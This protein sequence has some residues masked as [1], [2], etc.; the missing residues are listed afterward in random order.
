MEKSRVAVIGL[1]DIARKAYL[2][3][4][5]TRRDV[6]PH[7]L[8]RTPRTLREVAADYRVPDE[9]LFTTLEDLVRRPLDAAFVHTP[10]EH[11]PGIVHRLLEAGI[12]TYVDKPLDYTLEGARAL[13]ERARRNRVSLMVGFNR[14]HAPGYAQLRG[15][16]RD[17]VLMQKNQPGI[18]DSPRRTVYDDFVHIADTLRFLAPEGGPEPDADVS[19]RV[20]GEQLEH[21][22]LRLTRPGWTALGT[23]HRRSGSK[24]EKLEV[25]GEGEKH[26]VVN[27]SETV[28]HHGDRTVSRRGDWTPVARQRGIEQAC[29]AF[30][31]AIGEGRIL[32]AGDALHTHEL[33]ERIAVQAETG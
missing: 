20:E 1:G 11:H 28:E 15:R 23:M 17:L 14:R 8:T 10:T 26:E 32:D 3:V 22:A 6:A 30:L 21:V 31:D 27:L 12:P 19:V 2:P 5:A 18:G 29:T 16:P 13:V 33:C 24:E 9:Q 25:M 4:L 7:L